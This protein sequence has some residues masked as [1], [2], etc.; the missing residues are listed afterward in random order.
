MITRPL[1][2]ASRLQP[3]PRNFDALFYVNVGLLALFLLC[4]FGSRF[5]LAPGWASISTCRRWPEPAPGRPAPPA[6]ISIKSSGQILT[7]NGLL[8]MAQLPEWLKASAAKDRHPVLLIRA[9]W[10]GLLSRTSPRS[11]AW[12]KRRGWEWWRRPSRPRERNRMS[13]ARRESRGAWVISAVVAAAVLAVVLTLFR[14]PH[15][16]LRSFGSG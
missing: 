2:L 1:D 16:L 11:P 12:R 4:S 3:A 9:D 13:A 8:N 7:D 6:I 5:V 15:L 14:A 10:R